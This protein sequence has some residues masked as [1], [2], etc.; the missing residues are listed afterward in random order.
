MLVEI[1]SV[2]Q[3]AFYAG[4]GV[5]GGTAA[6]IVAAG[7]APQL[8]RKGVRIKAAL[9][10]GP[11]VYVYVGPSTVQEGTGFKLEAGAEVL[12]EMDDPSKVY[13]IGGGTGEDEVQTVTMAEVFAGD[14]FRLTFGGETTADLFVGTAVADVQTALEGLSEIGAGNVVVGGTSLL[15]GPITLTFQGELAGTN[16]AAVVGV[17]G[18]NAVQTVSI[19]DASSGGA[20]TLTLGEQTTA[21]IAYDADAA[22]VQ[23]ALEAA[24]GEGNV[25]VSGG[26]GPTLDWIVT[27]KNTLG[28][29]EQPPMTGDGN[30]L[31]G[32]STE[33]TIA[34]NASGATKTVEVE[35]TTAGGVIAAYS[36]IAC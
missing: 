20:F 1:G 6:P 27:F 10:N 36:W 7:H 11:E 19:D 30:L 18:T 3:S 15:D 5:V 12:V 26:P 17:G 34:I 4:A 33:V 2:V 22:A 24:L 28:H 32:G 35:E 21:A 23:A 9:A 25:E 14:V 16:V 31:E 13:V 29:V 8:L